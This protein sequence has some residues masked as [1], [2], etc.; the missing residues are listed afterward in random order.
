MS[1]TALLI[2][3]DCEPNRDALSRRLARG[4]HVA[5]PRMAPRR[6]HA[7]AAVA[8]DLVCWMSSCWHDGWKSSGASVRSAVA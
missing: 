2:V 7:F 4:I 5:T 6:W 1:S 3:D 8:Y